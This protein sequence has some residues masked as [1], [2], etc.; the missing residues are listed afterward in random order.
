MHSTINMLIKSML[1]RI[2][3]LTNIYFTIYK[4]SDF[5]Y[6]SSPHNNFLLYNFV[7]NFIKLL[8]CIILH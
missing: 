7:Y 2:N 1:Y 4:I 6:Y 3:C 5:I 8:R